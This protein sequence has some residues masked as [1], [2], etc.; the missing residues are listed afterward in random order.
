M[1]GLGYH[2][3]AQLPHRAV[4][5][6]LYEQR[7]YRLNDERIVIWQEKQTTDRLKHLALTTDRL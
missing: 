4:R 6:M 5:V 1:F 2:N 3:T 7:L